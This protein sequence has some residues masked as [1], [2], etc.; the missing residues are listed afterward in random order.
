MSI[1]NSK[2]LIFRAKQTLRFL[3]VDSVQEKYYFWGTLISG[4][5]MFCMHSWNYDRRSSCKPSLRCHL[6]ENAFILKNHCEVLYSPPLYLAV[7]LA[8]SRICKL[9]SHIISPNGL[10]RCIRVTY[11]PIIPQKFLKPLI[12]HFYLMIRLTAMFLWRNLPQMMFYQ[13]TKLIS[14]AWYE[15]RKEPQLTEIHYALNQK[16]IGK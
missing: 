2:T 11:S 8:I 4:E 14:L 3:C 7:A 12:N 15:I 10:S 1:P 5:T 13:H 16:Y 9:V 6:V